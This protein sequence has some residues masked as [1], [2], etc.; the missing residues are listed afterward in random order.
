MKRSKLKEIIKEEITNFLT[1]LEFGDENEYKKYVSQHKI[2]PGTTVT[3]GGSTMRTGEKGEL[4]KGDQVGKKWEK[5]S[6]KDL[7]QKREDNAEEV[8]DDYLKDTPSI[9]TD[10]GVEIERDGS[11]RVY[12]TS[13]KTDKGYEVSVYQ[14]GDDIFTIQGYYDNDDFE[15]VDVKQKNLSGKD[16]SKYF[17]QISK[18]VDK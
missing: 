7:A 12:D 5:M 10:S 1:E 15:Q 2:R 9:S 18:I 17:R 6:P 14:T 3:V 13:E 16:L 11:I 4:V 8:F